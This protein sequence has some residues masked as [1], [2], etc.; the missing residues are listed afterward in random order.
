MVD[1]AKRFIQMM[2][3]GGIV[4]LVGRWATV[5]FCFF[6]NWIFFIFNKHVNP[7]YPCSWFTVDALC[8]TMPI[9]CWILVELSAW[10]A[11]N[12]TLLRC[13]KW[14]IYFVYLFLKVNISRCSPDTCIYP[15][16]DWCIAEHNIHRVWLF[17]ICLPNSHHKSDDTIGCCKH[18]FVA[19]FLF[20]H[21]ATLHDIS[22]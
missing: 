8:H 14:L 9:C 6:R 15:V 10:I 3:V 13:D 12:G 17:R 4:N 20:I 11:Q 21:N 18:K 1:S 22:K 2:M 16:I 5:C 7:N 19:Q